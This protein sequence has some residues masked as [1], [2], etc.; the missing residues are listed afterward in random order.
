MLFVWPIDSVI[1]SARRYGCRPDKRPLVPVIPLVQTPIRNTYVAPTSPSNTSVPLPAVNTR[2]SSSELRRRS[3]RPPAQ[4]R[5]TQPRE[6]VHI[7]CQSWAVVVG[8]GLTRLK[9]LADEPLLISNAVDCGINC[10]SNMVFLLLRLLALLML[11][12]H[13]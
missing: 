8:A 4:R 5:Q 2:G 1:I 13:P 7:H 3:G 9:E 11:P 12:L 10:V 6:K